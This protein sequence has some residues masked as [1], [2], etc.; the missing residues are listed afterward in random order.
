MIDGVGKQLFD[1]VSARTS[2]F[3]FVFA[4]SFLRG[5]CTTKKGVSRSH[6]VDDC[7][8]SIEGGYLCVCVNVG[9]FRKS[10]SLRTE[11]FL[12]VTGERDLSKM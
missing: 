10:F 3:S 6:F 4:F 2:L 11:R 1:G 8:F 12:R 9:M 7:I 5:K